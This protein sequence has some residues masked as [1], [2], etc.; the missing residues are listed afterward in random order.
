MQIRIKIP[1]RTTRPTGV[2]KG[3][4]HSSPNP[5]PFKRIQTMREKRRIAVVSPAL[6][7]EDRAL[8]RGVASASSLSTDW[9]QADESFNQKDFETKLHASGRPDGLIINHPFP[10]FAHFCRSRNIPCVDLGEFYPNVD[11]VPRINTDYR[12]VGKLAHSHF[13][14][15]GHR[16]FAFCG[17]K[18]SLASIEMQEGFHAARQGKNGVNTYQLDPRFF[19]N[20]YQQDLSTPSTEV[21]IN[22]LNIWIRGLPRQTAIFA[23]SDAIAVHISKACEDSGLELPTDL[24]LLGVGNDAMICE[25]GSVPLSSIN[26]NPFKRGIIAADTVLE[27]IDAPHAP[28]PKPRIVPPL[29]V[30]SRFS[31]QFV[32]VKDQLVSKALEIIRKGACKGI[33]VDE[34]VSQIKTS[35]RLLERKFKTTLGKSPNVV[36]RETQVSEIKRLLTETSKPISEIAYDTGFENPEYLHVVFKREEGTTPGAYRQCRVLNL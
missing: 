4:R 7:E 26:T 21:F 33:R 18:G 34:V 9:L 27:M 23:A 16:S 25:L 11:G 12:E 15:Q 8:I 30:V 6:H 10:G 36:I 5:Q 1:R 32:A 24:S 28:P 19:S 31:S 35:R 14:E 3:A 17:I 22:S 13:S 29:G 20:S 2:N